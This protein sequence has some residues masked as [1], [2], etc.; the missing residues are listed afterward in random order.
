[1]G[2]PGYGMGDDALLKLRK[3]LGMSEPATGEPPGEAD[4]GDEEERGRVISSTASL[5]VQWRSV[6]RYGCTY[7]LQSSHMAELFTLG[8]LYPHQ[9]R[10]LRIT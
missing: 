9:R 1:M 5:Q 6:L 2:L 7:T 8:V 10:E 4:G 3:A